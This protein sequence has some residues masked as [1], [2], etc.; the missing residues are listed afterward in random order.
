MKLVVKNTAVKIATVNLDTIN[1][2]IDSKSRK[3]V[4]LCCPVFDAIPLKNDQ[5]EATQKGY[6]G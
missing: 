1:R 4:P 3:V 5:K 2:K 6:D